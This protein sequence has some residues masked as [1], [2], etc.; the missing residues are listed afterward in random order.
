MWAKRNICRT[1]VHLLI[2]CATHI[3]SNKCD[4]RKKC[5]IFVKSMLEPIYKIHIYAPEFK[6]LK[7]FTMQQH[8]KLFPKAVH[9]CMVKVWPT[10]GRDV[11]ESSFDFQ[12]ELELARNE[13]IWTESYLLLCCFV[14]AILLKIIWITLS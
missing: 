13:K 11:L 6:C 8:S 7:N 12:P 14:P 10:K 1:I 4:P 9:S 3:L 2:Q 5:F